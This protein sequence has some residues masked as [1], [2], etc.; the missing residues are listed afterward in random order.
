MNGAK[1]RRA[2]HIGGSDIRDMERLLGL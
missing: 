2:N 1:L